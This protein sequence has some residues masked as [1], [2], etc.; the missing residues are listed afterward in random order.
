[1]GEAGKEM[2]PNKDSS[3]SSSDNGE[4]SDTGKNSD[5]RG[6]SSIEVSPCKDESSLGGGSSLGEGSSCL[7]GRAPNEEELAG[8]EGASKKRKVHM[9]KVGKKILRRKIIQHRMKKLLED[10]AELPW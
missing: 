4:S 3:A 7:H 8:E 2:S 10:E 5:E 6:T 9:G 1:M